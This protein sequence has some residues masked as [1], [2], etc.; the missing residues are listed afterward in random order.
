MYTSFL[1]WLARYF[2]TRRIVLWLLFLCPMV[3]GG[4][5]NLPDTSTDDAITMLSLY[6]EIFDTLTTLALAP[7]V[8]LG[9]WF[10]SP[11]WTMGDIFDLREKFLEIWIIVS[12]LTYI[13]F[14][15]LLLGMAVIQIF[16]NGD[17]TFALKKKIRRFLIGILIVPFTWLIVS[18]TLSFV[19]QTVAVILAV[20]LGIIENGKI[21]AFD[22]PAI[23]KEID[24]T[25][26]EADTSTLKCTKDNCWTV[27]EFLVNDASPYSILLIFFY[28]TFRAYDTTRLNVDDVCKAKEGQA[29]TQGKDC[30]KAMIDVLK[31]S[32]L[33]IIFLIGMLFL[34][35]SLCWVLLF[36]VFKLWIYIVLSPLFWLAFALADSGLW[37]GYEGGWGGEG[38]QLG[39]LS[40]KSFFWLAFIPIY[41][42]AVLAFWFMAMAYIEE[43]ISSSE[44][45]ACSWQ[46]MMNV[47][48]DENNTIIY[49]WAGGTN[50][51]KLVFGKMSDFGVSEAAAGAKTIFIQVILS[52]VAIWLMFAGI[53]AAVWTDEITKSVF[54]PFDKLWWS[55]MSAAKQLPS[56]LPIPNALKAMTPWWANTLS[57]TIRDNVDKYQSARMEDDKARTNISLNPKLR[58]AQ[59]DI[60]NADS[61]QEINNL[62]EESKTTNLANQGTAGGTLLKMK[63]VKWFE[64]SKDQPG[65]TQEIKDGIT[66]IVWEIKWKSNSN[67]ARELPGILT[68]TDNKVLLDKMKWMNWEVRKFVEKLE[69]DM[70]I[71][72]NIKAD[73]LKATHKI[74]N[75]KIVMISDSSADVS[76]NDE[77]KAAVKSILRP[78]WEN[79]PDTDPQQLEDALI[80]L[81]IDKNAIDTLTH[82]ERKDI[83]DQLLVVADWSTPTPPANPPAP[84]R[85][86]P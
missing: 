43:G 5:W 62:P 42:T 36:R 20:P 81:G 46:F 67:I 76:L 86:N 73:P 44:S 52:L 58:K 34:S 74:K 65:A 23:P 71:V 64:L 28:H 69:N 68:D 8:L 2:T 18:F 22:T 80:K 72:A 26:T 1:T 40:L 61:V 84:T 53:K 12:N 15:M 50:E 41:V 79:I 82:S 16:G 77:Q 54:A 32:L 63:V 75:K 45:K 3:S 33:K 56:F 59:S 57:N 83:K 7:S 66:R 6:G 60:K 11:D 31:N 78:S 35:L 49:V 51:V 25:F 21:K 47:C 9:G 4:I 24:L 14:A 29:A 48:T 70:R 39:S 55:V 38:I 10:L 37:K 19:N 85:P 27:N 30:L 17:H 13:I